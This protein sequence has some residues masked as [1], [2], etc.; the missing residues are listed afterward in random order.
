MG[1]SQSILR[2]EQKITPRKEF[3]KMI[4]ENAVA[5]IWVVLTVVITEFLK[6]DF[7]AAEAKTQVRVKNA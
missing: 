7:W 5:Q 6:L 1:A 3:I 2:I 4:Q